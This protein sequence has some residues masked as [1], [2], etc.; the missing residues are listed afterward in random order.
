M[1]L[2]VVGGGG[3]VIVWHFVVAIAAVTFE[4]WAS[5]GTCCAICFQLETHHSMPLYP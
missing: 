1:M 3:A 2:M 4:L 5:S